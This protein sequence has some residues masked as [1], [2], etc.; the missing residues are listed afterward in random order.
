M[1]ENPAPEERV[2]ERTYPQ[3]CEDV[4]APAVTVE[5]VWRRFSVGFS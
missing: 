2:P 4:Q 5:S 3:G 1:P